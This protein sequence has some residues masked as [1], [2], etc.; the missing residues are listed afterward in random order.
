MSDSKILIVD[1]VNSNLFLLNLLLGNIDA[2]VIQAESGSSALEQFKE[3]SFNLAILDL[4]MPTMNGYELACEIRKIEG[5][6]SLPI[7]FLTADA[8]ASE[9]IQLCETLKDSN[10]IIKPLVKENLY[11]L[12]Q[13]HTK[14]KLK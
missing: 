13:E 5:Y 4:Y 6:E 14:L 9:L 8:Q 1:D 12:I 11:K 3:Q 10:I 7:F 2:E